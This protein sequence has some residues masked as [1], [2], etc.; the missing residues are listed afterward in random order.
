M[1]VCVCV[2][3]TNVPIKAE[4]EWPKRNLEIAFICE[5]IEEKELS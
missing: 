1:C 5:I 3:V 4:V 2:C